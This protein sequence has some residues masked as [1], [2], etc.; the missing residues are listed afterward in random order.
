MT[1]KEFAKL[2]GVSQSTVSRAMNDSDLVP[3]EKREFIQK[4]ARELGFVLNSQA[5][6]LRTKQTGTVGILFP[7]HFSGMHVNLSL[8]YL[9][10][11]VQEEL[12][13]LGYDVM[14]VYN[15][16]QSE[17][18][19][20][21]LERTIKQNKV[22]GFIVL[23]LD[24]SQ[25]EM[26]LF[27]RHQVP[28]VFLLNAALVD[29]ASSSCI[30]DSAYG[31]YLV[32]RYFG[33]FPAYTCFYLNVNATA[34]SQ[35]RLSGYIRGLKE[36]GVTLNKEHILECDLSIR[37][38]YDCI[39]ASEALIRRQKT[40]IFAYNDMIALGALNA[41][42]DLGLAVP[43]AVQIAGMDCQPMIA[44]FSPKLTTV[45]LFYSEI[46]SMGCELLRKSIED[47]DKKVVQMVVRPEFVRGCT[48]L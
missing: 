21:V 13:K 43:D 48:T 26:E 24:I 38:A 15:T 8:A 3:A 32:G 7:K 30:S 4:K 19:L 36:C 33:Q 42:R 41:C 35:N 1:S 5:R 40:A 29:A 23:K 28:C 2:I 25:E 17:D 6:S 34:D 45:E 39:M 47:T 20:S 12:H 14:M 46:A 9:Y 10:D 22:D 16:E 27:R 31:G 44:Q 18:G 37:S 11:L